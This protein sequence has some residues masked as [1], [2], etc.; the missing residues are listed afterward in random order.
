MEDWLKA[1]LRRVHH[2]WIP[3]S[4]AKKLARVSR[5]KYKCAHCKDLYGPKDI[6]VD[7]IEPVI[8]VSK[9]FMGWDE[10]INRLFLPIK[11]YQI[12]CKKCHNIKTQEENI[13]RRET[14]LIKD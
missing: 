4:E 10:Y 14:K 11:G 6:A 9:G 13:I 12:L 5:G 3:R 7:H 1:Q 8:E 2:K